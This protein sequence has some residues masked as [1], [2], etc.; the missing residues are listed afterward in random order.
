MRLI[1]LFIVFLFLLIIT[2]FNPRLDIAS[3]R[4]LYCY[5][6]M[7]FMSLF[8]AIIQVGGL[9]RVSAFTL[10]LVYVSLISFTF[11]FFLVY[12][13]P[14]STTILD[15]DLM[16]SFI[17]RFTQNKSFKIILMILI[18]Y[19]GSLISI[20][21]DYISTHES[22][23][24]LRADYYGEDELYGPLYSFL[25][26][27]IL[28]P[29]SIIAI[30][31]F[32]YKFMYQRD[33][34]CLLLG[35]F[36]F[37]YFTLSGGRFGYVRILFGFI[38]VICCLLYG[39]KRNHSGQRFNTKKFYTSFLILFTCVLIILM[40]VTLARNSEKDSQEES[41][42]VDGTEQL[43]ETAGNYLGGS[44]VAF[45]YCIENN[46]V[47]RIGGYQYGKLTLSALV[48]LVS[49]LLNK[50]GIGYISLPD[51]TFKQD[52]Y[53]DIG[54]SYFN[55]LYTALFWF[56]LDFGICGVL[57]FPFL[58]GV[59]FHYSIKML[60]KYNNF[61]MLI[62]VFF[63]F[64][65]VLYSVFDYTFVLYSELMFVFALFILRNKNIRL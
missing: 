43:S 58:F 51:I 37:G 50:L 39:S 55:A 40:L 10:T 29:F 24:N 6:L 46:Y 3:R 54:S 62:F 47:D 35:L 16:G 28:S 11:G 17:L 64:Q 49:P 65:K 19:I 22:L 13:P 27:W 31:I 45:D 4:M 26:I 18:V 34:I 2:K 42:L 63:I 5:Y 38:Y 59:I 60:Y 20:Y 23:A 15:A 21:I 14:Q 53:I 12:I 1:V 48:K 7:W 32:A 57:L 44:I 25:N 52:E 56:Y 33:W 8:F 30:P 61:Y 36:L 9:F 41:L